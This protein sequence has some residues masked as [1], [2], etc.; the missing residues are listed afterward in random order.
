MK[1]AKNREKVKYLSPVSSMAVSLKAVL[2]GYIN[3]KVKEQ[4]FTAVADVDAGESK[5]V[6]S[7]RKE[8]G[9]KEKEKENES[10]SENELKQEK[11][12]GVWWADVIKT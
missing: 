7:P 2:P 9:E 1:A 4:I 5:G 12:K 3:A 11:V 10:D 6:S 8:Q